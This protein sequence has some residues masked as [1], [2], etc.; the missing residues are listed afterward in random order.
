MKKVITAQEQFF[1]KILYTDK[2]TGE[3]NI[4]ECFIRCR[5]IS[6]ALVQAGFVVRVDKGS[7]YEVSEVL[8]VRK[9]S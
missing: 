4:K 3:Q 8:E 9:V 6:E 2:E 7:R 5:N 1:V